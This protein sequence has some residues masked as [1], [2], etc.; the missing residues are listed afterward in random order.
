MA[1][2]FLQ[3]AVLLGY[4]AV[5]VGALIFTMFKV[6]F[7][8]PGWVTRWSYGMMAPYQGDTSWNADFVY[9][10]ELPDG[11]RTVI[12]L[13][14]YMPYGFGERN[15]RKFLTAFKTKDGSLQRR[16]FTEFALLLLDRERARGNK[17]RAIRVYSE[18]WD[19]SPGGYAFL[20]TPVF[21]TREF[22]TQVQ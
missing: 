21:T 17:Y 12:N 1:C 22:L 18:R 16:K 8:F 10:G 9:E 3:R 19:R 11:T 2:R 6:H 7:L 5:T 14:P 4:L 20:H 13:D 15:Q